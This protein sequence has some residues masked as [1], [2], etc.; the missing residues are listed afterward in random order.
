ML[1]GDSKLV[2]RQLVEEV[3]SAL[4]EN[5]RRPS[6]GSG[7][8]ET[9]AEIAAIKQEWLAEWMPRSRPTTYPSAPYRVVWELNN[10]WTRPTASS[11]TTPATLATRLSPSTRPP[12]RAAISAGATST[13]LGAGLGYAM[14]AKLAAP[15]KTVVNLMGDTAVGMCGTRLRDRLP[16]QNRHHH[17]HHQQRGH[18]RLREEHPIAVE[19]YGSKFLTGDYTKMADSLGLPRRN[20]HPTRRHRPGLGPR[21]RHSVGRPAGGAGNH[22]PRRASVLAVLLRLERSAPRQFR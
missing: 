19:K 10:G 5:G 13:Q 4:G 14:G 1:L 20:H 15:Q 22:H 17:G 18:G 6:S 11:P 21:P 12:R 2:L 16:Q 8:S 9:A 3:K 7:Q